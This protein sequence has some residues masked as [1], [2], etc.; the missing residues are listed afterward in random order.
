MVFLDTV[1]SMA[2]KMCMD[3]PLSLTWFAVNRGGDEKT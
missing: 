3:V 1:L 2:T